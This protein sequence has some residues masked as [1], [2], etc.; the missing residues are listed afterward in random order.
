MEEE[1]RIKSEDQGKGLMG[2]P[3]GIADILS[4]PSASSATQSVLRSASLFQPFLQHLAVVAGAN[5]AVLPFSIENI[6]NPNFP[7]PIR[8]DEET[9][10]E[11]FEEGRRDSP[12]EANSSSHHATSSSPS[13]PPSISTTPPTTITTAIPTLCQ[14]PA[15]RVKRTAAKKK[16][17]T[18]R[19]EWS[20]AQ[21]D[22]YGPLGSSA[23]DTQIDPQ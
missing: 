6:L 5:R 18:F 23:H 7:Q 20:E 3:Y 8:K 13:P 12:L 9:E 4:R 19:Q 2:S 11:E 10:D 1:D 15:Q 21:M 22:S 16:T 14:C 17:L